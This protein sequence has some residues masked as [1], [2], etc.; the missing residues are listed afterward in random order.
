MSDDEGILKNS[1]IYKEFKEE[2]EEVL[3]HKWIESEKAGHDIGLEMA[4]TD[5]MIKHRSKWLKYRAEKNKRQKQE[6]FDDLRKNGLSID[7]YVD[8]NS[9]R[10]YEPMGENSELKRGFSEITGYY[11]L[12]ADGTFKRASNL[13]SPLKG[14]VFAGELYKNPHHYRIH[15]NDGRAFEIKPEDKIL[16]VSV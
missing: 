1:E 4:L 15:L 14:G 11:I 7:I 9:F 8:L 16:R 13:D 12:N 2:R 10:T 5:W 3:K 6:L